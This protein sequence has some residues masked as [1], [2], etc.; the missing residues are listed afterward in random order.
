MYI[1]KSFKN[2]LNESSYLDR[3]AK[4]KEELIS[5]VKSFSDIDEDTLREL[6]DII[7]TG[8]HIDDEEELFDDLLEK[9]EEWS[10]LPNPVTL[11]RVVAATDEKSVSRE[12]PGPHWTPYEWNL[13]GDM[14]MSIGYEDWDD[15]SKPFVIVASVPHDKIDVIKTV[16]HNM[17]YQTEHEITVKDNG[18]GINITDVYELD[19]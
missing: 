8:E 10:K 1:E 17:T 13:D 14:M 19:M 6:F 16:A 4:K 11:Y 3:H 15:E 7:P 2:F 18:R 5:R 9:Y 12:E